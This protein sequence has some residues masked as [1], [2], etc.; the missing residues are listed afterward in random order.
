MRYVG[1]LLMLLPLAASG[2]GAKP[3]PAKE[4]LSTDPHVSLVKTSKRDLQRVI[5]QPSFIDSYEQ[6]AIYAKL[7]AYVLR[8]NVD[9]GDPI[10][11]NQVLATLYIPELREEVALKKSQVAMDTALVRQSEKL[12]EVAQGNLAAARAQVA[13]AK[14]NVGQAEAL[15]V[16]WESEVRRETKLVEEDVLDEQILD[17]STRQL[18]ASIA[19]RAAA[20]AAVQTA[21]A[22][23]VSR[24]ADL[25]KARVDVDVAKARLQVADADLKRVEAL[26]SYT[27]L[28]APYDGI[29]VLRNINTGDFVLPA[30]GDPSAAARSGDKSAAEATPIYVVARTDVVRVY[31][32]VPEQDANYIVSKVEK[33]SGDPRTVTKGGVLVTAFQDDEIPG[34]VTR[35]SWALNFKS[36]TLRAEIDLHNPD[37]RLLP[38]MYAYG[39]VIFDRKNATVLPRA[40][41]TEI[42]N[43]ECCYFYEN[44]KAVQIPVETGVHTDDWVEILNKKVGNDW[45]NFDGTEQVILGNMS[46]IFD[47]EKVVVDK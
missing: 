27:K 23:L 40:T 13:E 14:A 7:P 11:K 29:V 5:G 24:T 17:E 21:E 6:T 1:L 34:E 20:L 28:L 3:L 9:I 2:C 38:G 39:R 45:K 36:R 32:D 22:D 44:G 18:Q 19:S 35:S 4:P 33:R 15:V 41:I 16:R 25:D 10:K 12:V 31:V 26:F 43:Q 8:W 30:T 42:G 47:G 37:A 46:E